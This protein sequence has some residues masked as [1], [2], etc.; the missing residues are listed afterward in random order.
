MIAVTRRDFAS[1]ATE[2]PPTCDCKWLPCRRRCSRGNRPIEKGHIQIN[3]DKPLLGGRTLDDDN[4]FI[5]NDVSYWDKDWQLHYG[6][7]DDP[8]NRNGF[9]PADF[10]PK[11]NPFYVALPYGEFE[12]TRGH[13]LRRDA[14]DIPWYR[15]D[16]AP[17]LRITGSRSSLVAGRATRSGR[18]LD[19]SRL[20][21]LAMCS[22]L[23]LTL[24]TPLT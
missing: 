6:G 2:P 10:R 24:A 16:L 4:A 20:M 9:W 13:D 14:Q 11:E 7:V 23:P 8:H 22:G 18:M 1:H 5:P 12:L 3:D 19:H 15:H 17:L 21:I